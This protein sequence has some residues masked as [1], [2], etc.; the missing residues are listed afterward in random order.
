M[1]DCGVC[2]DDITEILS[3]ILRDIKLYIKR[4]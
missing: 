3:Y 4:Y 1:L 2:S